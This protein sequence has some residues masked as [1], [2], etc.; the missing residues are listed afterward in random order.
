MVPLLPVDL[1]PPQHTR[2]RRVLNKFFTLEAAEAVCECADEPGDVM[3]FAGPYHPCLTRTPLT[4]SQPL[5]LGRSKRSGHPGSKEGAGHRHGRGASAASLL[6]QDLQAALPQVRLTSSPAAWWRP[7]TD[8]LASGS[9]DHHFV[10]EIDND[11]VAH[12]RFGYG[13]TGASPGA[14]TTFSATLAYRFGEAAGLP[15]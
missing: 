13:E 6:R 12:L 14:A 7:R 4:F 3:T 2:W 1:D 5:R 10:V 8:L 9:G 11:G 15:A